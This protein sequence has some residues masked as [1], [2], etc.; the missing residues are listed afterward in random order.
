MGFLS[1]CLDYGIDYWI[2]EKAGTSNFNDESFKDL[3]KLCNRFPSEFDPDEYLNESGDGFIEEK[4]LLEYVAIYEVSNY[5]IQEVRANEPVTFIGFPTPDGSSGSSIMTSGV[6]TIPTGSAH[7]EGAWSF[8]KFVL[9]NSDLRRQRSMPILKSRLETVFT[10]AI[11]PEY[12]FDEDGN[13]VLDDRGNQIEQSKYGS[14]FG[15]NEIVH[16][17]YAVTEDELAGVRA[18]IDSLVIPPKP[19]AVYNIIKEEAEAYFVGQKTLDEVVDII[20]SR[21]EVYVSENN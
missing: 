10:N 17:L 8:I 19:D 2:D 15:N 13:P 18:F 12:E 5:L 21:V 9:Q 7:K 20:Q 14:V 1:Y 6:Y 3:L 11:T 4:Y 16:Y